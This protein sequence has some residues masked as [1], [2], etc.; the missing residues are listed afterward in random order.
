MT[1]IGDQLRAMLAAVM[2]R[3]APRRLTRRERAAGELALAVLR[4]G[5]AK[6]GL[7]PEGHARADVG[8][9]YGA[10]NI[11]GMGNMRRALDASPLGRM[12]RARLALLLRARLRA[13]RGDCGPTWQIECETCGGAGVVW[14][15]VGTYEAGGWQARRCIACGGPRAL[16]RRITP[17]WQRAR[18]A[19]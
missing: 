5:A 7:S 18:S 14:D 16:T 10:I 2:E 12:L 9:A 11:G 1:A 8:L 17:L 3:P 13:D 19:T 15:W 6:R 4:R